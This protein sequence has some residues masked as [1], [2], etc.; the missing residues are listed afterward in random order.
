MFAKGGRN[1][2]NITNLRGELKV[3]FS[4]IKEELE[5]HLESINQ[6]TIEIQSSFEYLSRL[7]NR[8]DKIEQRLS[9]MELDG[10]RDRSIETVLLT[11]DEEEIYAILVESTTR[12][13]LLSYEDVAHKAQISKTFCAHLIAS[14]IDKGV[15]VGKKFSNGNVLLEID[16]QHLERGLSIATID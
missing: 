9:Q 3:V 7:S 1:E 13:Q 11:R 4:K 16:P 14:L 2:S 8:I 15:R 5:D 12:R 10:P 6:N